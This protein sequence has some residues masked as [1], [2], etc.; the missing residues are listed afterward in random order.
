MATK[1]TTTAKPVTAK[2]P[3]SEASPIIL[4]EA[5]AFRKGKG[6]VRSAVRQTIE[7]L[8]VGKWIVL[9]AEYAD[10]EAFNKALANA[11]SMVRNVTLETGSKY[12]VRGTENGKVA[13]GRT[14]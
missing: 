12:S 6:R 1:N 13:I 5:P 11:R 7:T 8:D 3:V 14:A 4:D 2:A 10:D 9:D